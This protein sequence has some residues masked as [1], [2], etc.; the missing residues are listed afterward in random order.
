MNFIHNFQLRLLT[1]VT[2]DL[3][4]SSPSI[5]TAAYGSVLK[6]VALGEDAARVG[7]GAGFLAFLV[8]ARSSARAL[9]FDGT[10][11]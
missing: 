5:R 6:R 2:V 3:R 11:G 1:F 10:F 9:R 7:D 4:V 8:D